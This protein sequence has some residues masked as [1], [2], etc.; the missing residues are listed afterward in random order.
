L[1]NDPSSVD[2]ALEAEGER[3]EEGNGTEN[4]ELSLIPR[5][6]EGGGGSAQ[7]KEKKEGDKGGR[8]QKLTDNSTST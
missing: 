6:K 3:A 1:L 4:S 5:E 2:G 7:E 8:L